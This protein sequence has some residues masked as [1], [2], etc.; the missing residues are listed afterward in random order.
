MK[1]VDLSALTRIAQV[2]L[3]QEFPILLAI[4]DDNKEAFRS[5]GNIDRT[6]LRRKIVPLL[7]K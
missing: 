4:D 5:V 3:E 2:D 6:I 1:D 7:D